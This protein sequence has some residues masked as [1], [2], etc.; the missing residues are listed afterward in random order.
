MN[1]SI[2]KTTR[3]HYATYYRPTYSINIAQWVRVQDARR[4]VKYAFRPHFHPY[5]DRI[6]EQLNR[7]GLKGMLDINF[8]ESLDES[9]DAIPTLK[10]MYNP[11][12]NVVMEFPRRTLDVSDHGPYSVYNWELFFH[13]PLSIAVQLSRS[14][15]FAEAQRWFHFIFDPTATDKMPDASAAHLRY[16]RFLRFRQEKKVKMVD[17]LLNILSRPPD[18]LTVDDRRLQE[19]MKTNI[20]AWRDRPFQPHV[21]AR[22][23]FVAY[24]LAVVMKYLDNLVAWGDSLFRQF[25]IESINEAQ[26]LYV[27]A[28]NILGDKPQQTPPR[29]R[30]Q[31]KTFRELRGGLD[32]FGNALVDMENDFLFNL[33]PDTAPIEDLSNEAASQNLPQ[34]QTLLGIGR[35]LYFCVPKNDKLLSYWDLVA[36]RLYKIRNSMDIEGNVRTLALFDPPIDPSVLVRAAASGASIDSILAA[37]YQPASHVRATILIQK[38]LEICS[39]LKSLGSALLSS[40]E[41]GDGERLANL[42]QDNELRLLKLTN[43]I[44]F[45]QWKESESSTEGLLKSRQSAFL[46]YNHYQRLLGQDASKFEKLDLKRAP[47][48]IENFDSTYQELV[49]KYT[50][51]L[52]RQAYKADSKPLAGNELGLNQREDLELNKL[53]PAA[54]ELQQNAVILDNMVGVLALFPQID[55]HG[56]PLGVG[57]AAGF[58]GVQLSK[59]AEIGAKVARFIADDKNYQAGRAAKMSSYQ[60]RIED[61]TLQNNLAAS[62][63][64]QIG[65]QIIGSL[66][67]EQITKREYDSHQV[68]MEQ[69]EAVGEMMRTKFSNEDLYKWM[70]GELQKLYSETYKFVFDIAKRAEQTMKTELSRPELDAQSFVKFNYWDGGRKGLLSGETLWLDLKKM[71]MAYLENNKREYEI[72]KHISLRQLNP[73]ALLQLKATGATEMLVPEWLFDTECP[74]QFMRRI[75][76]VAISVPCIAGPYTSVNCKLTLLKHTTRVSALTGDEYRPVDITNDSRFRQS[77]GAVQSIVTSSGQNDSG[78]FETNLRDDRYLP[79]EGTGVEST[80]RI[81]LLGNGVRQFDFDSISDVILHVRYT[82]REAGILRGEAVTYL[83]ET[84]LPT[85]PYLMLLSLPHDYSTEWYQFISTPA[86]S[87]PLSIQAEHLPYWS[88]AVDLDRPLTGTLYHIKDGKKLTTL[89]ANL[90]LEKQDNTWIKTLTQA[91]DGTLLTKLRGLAGTDVFLLVK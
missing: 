34:T 54:H 85:T 27:L 55:A 40:I 80:W 35:S 23:R 65:R 18:E 19:D 87:L 17:K 39:E 26:Q 53:L 28:A 76:S 69:S 79:F 22:G 71:E 41:K 45:L 16:W 46:R 59:A 5:S 75:K 56:T 81:D 25:N 6:I 50:Q 11:T 78:L 14:Q 47:L 48:S 1:N 72:T 13:A 44:K 82:A 43:E 77:F 10:S 21:V 63:L 52:P 31:V 64:V 73:I 15:R 4:E 88:K 74:G 57:A 33:I 7:Y 84:A 2:I 70:Q 3:T 37:A 12:D 83:K 24:E 38:A 30:P 36:D 68:Q 20:Q 91:T 90:S 62:E 66:I 8:Q 29:G 60:R 9:K 67:R 61:W 89:V 32:T 86:A 51:D 49:G 42:R 58:G